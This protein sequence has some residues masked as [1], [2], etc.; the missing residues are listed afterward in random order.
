MKKVE[1][2]GEPA[3]VARRVLT[4][5]VYEGSLK[6]TKVPNEKFEPRSTRNVGRREQKVKIPNEKF[7][8]RF[9]RNVGG[10]LWMMKIRTTGQ[11]R[12]RRLMRSMAPGPCYQLPK[13]DGAKRWKRTVNKTLLSI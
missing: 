6:K 7:E 5:A 8:P 10:E 9:A 2:G 3:A 4:V 13:G 12:R 11:R 1:T